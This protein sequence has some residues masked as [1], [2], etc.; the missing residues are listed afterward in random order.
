MLHWHTHLDASKIVSYL[1][2][3]TIENVMGIPIDIYTYI[4]ESNGG[5][6]LIFNEDECCISSGAV[7]AFLPKELDEI[8]KINKNILS[9]ATIPCESTGF[10]RAIADTWFE[11]ETSI[12]QLLKELFGDA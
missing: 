10:I 4:I 11:T 6:Y 2:L 5:R 8:L 7:Y 1:P 3:N 9:V 12:R